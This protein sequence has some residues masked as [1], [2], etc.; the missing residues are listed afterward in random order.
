[1]TT[2]MTNEPDAHSVGVGGGPAVVPVR[3]RT[4]S[5][6]AAAAAGMASSILAVTGMVLLPNIVPAAALPEPTGD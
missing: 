2:Q 1:M 5:V 3:R 6:E 4:A